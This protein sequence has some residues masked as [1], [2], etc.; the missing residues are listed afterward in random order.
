MSLK[1][2]K[3]SE[4]SFV[5]VGDYTKNIKDDLVILGGIWNQNLKIDNQPIK[6]WIF[7]NTNIN[8]VRQLLKTKN[9]S[10]IDIKTT[11]S[12]D[13]IKELLREKCFYLYSEH[14]DIN[15]IISTFCAILDS[16]NPRD[17]NKDSLIK[18]I[19]KFKKLPNY[20][21]C[22]FKNISTSLDIN[23]YQG[24]IQFRL[25]KLIFLLYKLEQE[26]KEET[27]VEKLVTTEDVQ[28]SKVTKRTTSESEQESKL[29][30]KKV[31]FE[32][33]QESK[34]KTTSRSTSKTRSTSEQESKTK[35]TRTTSKTKYDKEGQTRAEVDETDPLFLFYSSL[36]NERPESKMA[37][38]WLTQHGC[39]EDEERDELYEKYKNL[40]SSSKQIKKRNLEMLRN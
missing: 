38:T 35:R 36:Y 24:D 6:G 16:Y 9:I 11:I 37:I 18:L 23:S 26:V 31:T 10:F 17:G 8:S 21:Q 4:K 5:L 15:N 27:H 22:I 33:D 13:N 20:I 28:E 2:L 39:F 32:D 7:S 19:E 12:I 3:Y 14:D 1:L 34:T 29:P 40:S 25:K 30:K